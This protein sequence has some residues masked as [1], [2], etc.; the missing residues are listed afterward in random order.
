MSREGQQWQDQVS[1]M[2]KVMADNRV[3]AQKGLW[4]Y[5]RWWSISLMT[6]DVEHIF[7]HLLATFISSLEECLF[8]SF[9]LL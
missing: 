9:A 5:V 6:N 3:E 4:L 1:E 2:I 8:R 7:M